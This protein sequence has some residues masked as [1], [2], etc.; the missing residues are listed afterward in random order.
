LDLIGESAELRSVATDGIELDLRRA[1]N[2]E[3]N[4][5]SLAPPGTAR[6]K[7]AKPFRFRIGSIAVNHGTVRVADASVAP[8]F[9]STLSDVAIDVKNLASPGDQKASVTLSFATDQ[10]AR[11][12]HR[13]TL[14][15]TPVR[16]DGRLEIAGLKLG[17]IYPYYASALNLAVD[18]GT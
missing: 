7:A 1:A 6:S 2:G 9:A 18:D 14:T 10:G 4:L 12:A 8:A 17:H 11:I 13:G 3:L 15:L 5:A 16:A